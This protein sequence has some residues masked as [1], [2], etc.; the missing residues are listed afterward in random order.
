IQGR[1]AQ[2]QGHV[3]DAVALYEKTL[4]VWTAAAG[5][6]V[7]DVVTL[8]GPK[9]DLAAVH[10]QLG[11]ADYSLQKYDSA[12]SHFDA[13]LKAHPRNSYVIFLRARSKES[14]HLNRAATDDYAL[15]TQT[16]RAQNDSSWNVAQAHYYRGLLLYQA[17]DSP[18]AEGEFTLASSRRV[19]ESGE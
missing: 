2:Q 10:Y 8:L 3:A 12:I 13:S 18:A 14:L 16:A 11:L 4:A 5:S 1:L 6:P 19:G 17:K 7:P 9:L 15:A